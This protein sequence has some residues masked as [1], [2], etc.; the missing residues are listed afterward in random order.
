MVSIVIPTFNREKTIVRAVNSVLRQTYC[1]IE[2]IVVDDGS[3]DKTRMLL[4]EIQDPRIRYIYQRNSGACAARNKGIKLAQ[5]DYI[6][7]QDS[8]DIWHEDKLEQQMK[9]MDKYK[10]DILFCQM[11]RFDADS[12]QENNTVVPEISHSGFLERKDIVVGISTQCLLTKSYVAKDILF[13]TDMPRYQDLDWLLRA[14]EKYSL[15]GLKEILVDYYFS[16]DSISKSNEKMLTA[17]ALLSRKWP[18]MKADLPNIYNYLWVRLVQVG[19]EKYDLGDKDY[20]KYLKTGF[21]HS[22][23]MIDKLKYVLICIGLFEPLRRVR[24]KLK[25]FDTYQ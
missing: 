1:D 13:D 8:D 20:A 23:R 19:R 14:T 11:I 18:K 6:A 2:V 15:F 16:D 7:F 9:I 17:L 24:D 25:K 22:P 21:Y 4:D 12:S 5:G 10:P 3:Q